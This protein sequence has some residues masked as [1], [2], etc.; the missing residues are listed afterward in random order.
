MILKKYLMIQSS[1]SGF[2]SYGLCIFV[3]LEVVVTQLTQLAASKDD[4][5][6]KINKKY[7]LVTFDLISY[8]NIVDD[9]ALIL[10]MFKNFY[11]ILVV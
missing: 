7:F 10:M 2:Y 4:L 8:I 5:V 3:H 6:L 9:N 11:V 1:S